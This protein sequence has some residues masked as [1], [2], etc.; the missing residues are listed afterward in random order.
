VKPL[1]GL[2]NIIVMAVNKPELLQPEALKAQARATFDSKRE[3][4]QEGGKALIK[5]VQKRRQKQTRVKISDGSA[6]ADGADD[7]GDAPATGCF[8]GDGVPL[9]SVSEAPPARVEENVPGIDSPGKA[10]T[11]NGLGEAVAATGGASPRCPDVPG[12]EIA[13]G[14]AADLS[15]EAK[16]AAA[17]VEG[18]PSDKRE[19]LGECAKREVE[20]K[21]PEVALQP[22]PPPDAPPVP[23]IPPP[24]EGPP[25]PKAPPPP[26]SP[27]PPGAPLPPEPPPQLDAP[28][29]T[30]APPEAAPEPETEKPKAPDDARGG[31]DAAVDLD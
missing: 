14:E 5:E 19:E 11:S 26:E 30:V 13:I 22:L 24:P 7:S 29:E 9:G 6:L 27:S 16:C 18:S 10:E 28:P 1:K 23:E 4:L 25:T 12:G 3:D 21:T 15:A 8:M 17:L 20:E 31:A 2:N